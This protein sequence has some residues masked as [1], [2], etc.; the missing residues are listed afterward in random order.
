[1][2]PPEIDITPLTRHPAWP[3]LV[4]YFAAAE[5]AELSRLRSTVDDIANRRLIFLTRIKADL[6]NRS[7]NKELWNVRRD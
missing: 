7:E 6:R 1:M 3:A 4:R 5:E 2:I